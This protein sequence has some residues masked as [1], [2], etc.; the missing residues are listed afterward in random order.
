MVKENKYQSQ[1]LKQKKI[2]VRKIKKSCYN[3]YRR[4]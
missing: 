3:D 2:A 1:A 4:F